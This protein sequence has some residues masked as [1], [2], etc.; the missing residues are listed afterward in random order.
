MLICLTR[1]AAVVTASN[2]LVRSH[3]LLQLAMAFRNVAAA[4]SHIDNDELSKSALEQAETFLRRASATQNAN[5]EWDDLRQSLI[6]EHGLFSRQA[7]K[8]L[9]KHGGLGADTLEYSNRMADVYHQEVLNM[10]QTVDDDSFDTIAIRMKQVFCEIALL[11]YTW[12]ED[13]NRLQ[14][15]SIES[16]IQHEAHKWIKRASSLKTRQHSAASPL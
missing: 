3:E 5:T 2:E 11:F 7:V 6:F 16:L 4:Y 14:N 13:E 8:Q 10:I 15:A 12:K 1:R 9:L